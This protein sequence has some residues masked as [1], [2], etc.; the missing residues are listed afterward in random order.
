MPVLIIWS[1][2]MIQ[3][4]GSFVLYLVPC[5][6]IQTPVPS[7]VFMLIPRSQCKRWT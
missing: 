4:P 1:R 6:L 5:I 2:T 3:S 7:Y